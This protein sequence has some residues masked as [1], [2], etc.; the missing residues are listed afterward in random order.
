MHFILGSCIC[1]CYAQA[2]YQSNSQTFTYAFNTFLPVLKLLRIAYTQ[3]SK[4]L[5]LIDCRAQFPP[6]KSHKMREAVDMKWTHAKHRAMRTICAWSCAPCM[7]QARKGQSPKCYWEAY[8]YCCYYC[9]YSDWQVR[10]YNEKF[11]IPVI[12]LMM[13]MMLVCSMAIKT[14]ICM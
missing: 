6:L 13:K 4:E 9:Y 12:Y 5:Q 1:I 11:Y 8:T 10:Y 3:A 7:P 2:V 14:W